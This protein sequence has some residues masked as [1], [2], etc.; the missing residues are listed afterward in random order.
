MPPTAPV[1]NDSQKNFK[2]NAHLF[3]LFRPEFLRIY[4]D[5]L[6]PDAFSRFLLEED[7]KYHNDKIRQATKYL[8]EVHIPEFAYKLITEIN[9]EFD[10]CSA[11]VNIT[12][13]L[14]R[15]GINVRYL[16]IHFL[17][18]ILAIFFFFCWKLT[19]SLLLSG[20]V[21]KHLPSSHKAYRDLILVEMVARSLKNLLR[22]KLRNRVRLLKVPLEEPYQKLVVKYLN[23]IFSNDPVHI[24]KIWKRYVPGRMLK[25]FN[26]PEELLKD[27][28]I[29]RNIFS[30]TFS[31]DENN[32]G[33]NTIEGRLMLLH[34]LS[35]LAGLALKKEIYTDLLNDPQLWDI[36]PVFDNND[37][38]SLEE[39][40][41]HMSIV[42]YAKGYIKNFIFNIFGELS[43][44]KVHVSC[45]GTEDLQ[46]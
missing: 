22:E 45:Q 19:W 40:V 11:D 12:E 17:T 7:M 14:H 13:E 43:L 31:A 39:K 26:F 1:L 34:R 29:R 27:L 8:E 25:D 32:F 15:H 37:L 36:E 16:G 41:K 2:R 3:Q 46:I 35:D 10:G 38:L 28:K 20:L 30:S 21:Y 9:H 33:K 18:N 4:K 44:E 5:E 23:M 42:S 6:C 24:R